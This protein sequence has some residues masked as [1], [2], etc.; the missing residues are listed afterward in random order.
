M[1]NSF[2]KSK[3]T[4]FLVKGLENPQVSPFS[5]IILCRPKNKITHKTIYRDSMKTQSTSTT[6]NPKQ[7][8]AMNII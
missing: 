7:N 4:F 6:E 8:F 1:L 3:Y 5:L 2:R